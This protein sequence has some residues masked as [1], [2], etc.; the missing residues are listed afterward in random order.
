[1]TGPCAK[2]PSW[3]T[4]AAVSLALGA[5]A[6]AALAADDPPYP[7]VADTSHATKKAAGLFRGFFT[8]KSGHDADALMTYFARDPVLYVD[9]SSGNQ[10]PTWQS[11]W[12][13]FHRFLPPA[14]ADA[15]SYPLRII[16]DEH[17]AVVE[18]EDTPSLF[19]R[20]LRIL[21][22]VTFDDEGKI[23]RW[24]DYWDGRSSQR[25]TSIQTTY[26][27]DFH[28]QVANASPEITRVADALQQA[29]AAGDAAGAASLFSFDAVYEDMAAHLRLVGRLQIQRYLERGLSEVPYGSGATVAHVVGGDE[30]GG[31]EWHAA[32]STAPMRR[33]N[34]ALE[35]DTNGK[36]SRLTTVYD[37][38]LLPYERYRRLVLL[39]A[40]ARVN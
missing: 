25:Q 27:T 3:I 36:I 33:G 20:E 13:V 2:R 35:L 4:A 1:V 30:G 37:S 18:F 9:A 19:G 14:P 8:A 29:F 15:L 6:A 22:S 40:E 34:T 38:G 17:S 21:G 28:D 12:D 11:L 24:V 23:V 26:P 10:W 16:G 7:D 32:P 31:Y 39:G 5:A